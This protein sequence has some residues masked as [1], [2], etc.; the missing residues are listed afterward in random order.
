MAISSRQSVKRLCLLSVSF[1]NV[2][3]GGYGNCPN[4]SIRNRCG[5]NYRLHS[6]SLP[7]SNL[8][9][10]ISF[11][12]LRDIYGKTHNYL[13]FAGRRGYLGKYP[14]KNTPLAVVKVSLQIFRV[15]GTTVY[16]FLGFTIVFVIW[17]GFGLV[18]GGRRDLESTPTEELNTPILW[19]KRLTFVQ[20]GYSF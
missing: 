1:L 3:G 7:A 6:T 13:G 19:K 5:R 17:V 10:N 14:N 12:F 11:L 16:V 20:K 2:E 9:Q 8:F 18:C 4:F 15:H